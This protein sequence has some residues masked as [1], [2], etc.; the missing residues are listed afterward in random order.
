MRVLPS[1]L[2]RLRGLIPCCAVPAA[3]PAMPRPIAWAVRGTG[4]SSGRPRVVP[5]A[6]GRRPLGMRALEDATV[7][8]RSGELLTGA[9]S[10]WHGIVGRVIVIPVAW[11]GGLR[12]PVCLRQSFSN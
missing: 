7:E 6:I 2:R 10:F 3:E 4:L 1:A 5:H 11:L 8:I 12:Q 9:S